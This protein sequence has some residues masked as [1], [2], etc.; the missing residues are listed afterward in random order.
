VRRHAAADTSNN[1]ELE[2]LNIKLSRPSPPKVSGITARAVSSRSNQGGASARIID[3]DCMSRGQG[4]AR[5]GCR[6]FSDHSRPS[7]SAPTRG[8]HI[9][10]PLAT[11]TFSD[12][13][14]PSR[15]RALT[16]LTVT[17]LTDQSKR[18]SPMT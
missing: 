3:S 5:P 9:Q 11:L 4:P 16:A 14:L 15:F 18:N 12:Q 8:P 1:K 2:K 17:A 10:R 7:H 13:S 6:R